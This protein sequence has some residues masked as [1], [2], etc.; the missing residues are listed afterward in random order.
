VIAAADAVVGIAAA[1]IIATV[2]EAVADAVGMTVDVRRTARH[3]LF[4]FQEAM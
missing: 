3:R 2:V 1:I 4:R